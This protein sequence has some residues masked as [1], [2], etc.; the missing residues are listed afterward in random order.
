MSSSDS[1]FSAVIVSTII[2]ATGLMPVR[3]ELTL[4]LGLLLGLL[5]SSAASSSSPSRGGG[6][7][8]TAGADGREN[9]LHVLALESLQCN[10]IPVSYQVNPK[11]LCPSR[12]S[13]I[14]GC[15]YLGE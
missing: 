1:S 3:G 12:K 14:F 9:V 15:S 11:P 2:V 5:G 6:S 10:N 8:T 4:F 13:H 7:G